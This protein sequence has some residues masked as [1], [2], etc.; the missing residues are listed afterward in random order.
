LLRGLRRAH[1]A[2]VIGPP[3]L[4]GRLASAG[5][6]IPAAPRSA[7]ARRP[8]WVERASV[9]FTADPKAVGVPHGCR[10]VPLGPEGSCGR[11][12]LS[13]PFRAP[14][15]TRPLTR[16]PQL[17]SGP[18]GPLGRPGC[19]PSPSTA[20]KPVVS[21][22]AR[23]RVAPA[24]PEGSARLARMTRS[25]LR[26]PKPPKV[27]EGCR[28]LPLNPE[29]FAGR[30]WLPRLSRAVPKDHAGPGWPPLRA[31]GARRRQLP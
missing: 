5:A 8:L 21:G 17:P 28:R 12:W 18:E 10:A 19:L 6:E 24:W 13:R 1:N 29:G 3:G 27:G 16:S 2:R 25:S 15:G 26:R 7:E 11:A 30:L 14:E 9:Q 31:P 4:R 22:L 23:P 20:G